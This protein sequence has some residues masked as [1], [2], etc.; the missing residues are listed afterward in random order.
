MWEILSENEKL[1]VTMNENNSGMTLHFKVS[2][3]DIDEDYW[4]E[5]PYSEWRNLIRVARTAKHFSEQQMGISVN[6]GEIAVEWLSQNCIQL[7]VEM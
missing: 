1:W 3:S 4:V 2:Q 6:E 7:N 5:L